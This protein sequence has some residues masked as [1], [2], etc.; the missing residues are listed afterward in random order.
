[1]PSSPSSEAAVSR[2]RR[3]RGYT[4]IELLLA[5]AIVVLLAAFAAFAGRTRADQQGEGERVLA[6]ITR[7]VT[8]RQAQVRQLNLKSLTG[9]TSLEAP[10]KDASALDVDFA[11]PDTTRDVIVSGVDANGDHIDDYT[12]QQLAYNDSGTLRVGFAGQPLSMPTGWSVARTSDDL[13]GIP[14]IGGGLRQ[15]GRVARCV[16][17]GIDGSTFPRGQDPSQAAKCGGD[18]A[19][20]AGSRTD[21]PAAG[22]SP[23]LAVYAIFTPRGSTSA[24][25][26]VALAIYPSGYTEP[27]RWDGSAW[28]GY[29]SRT[30]GN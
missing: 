1:M 23:F 14:M 3:E 8:T 15:R 17:F 22:E 7:V 30:L 20:R 26:A 27:F 28:R 29:N 12:G 13:H 18:D 5:L 19:S 16:S 24:T 21:A 2:R 9:G 11:S 6:D 25:G 10:I 4:L